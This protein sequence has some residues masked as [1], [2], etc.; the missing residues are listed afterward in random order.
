MREKWHTIDTARGD[1]VLYAFA[2]MT[3]PRVDHREPL[4]NPYVAFLAFN[5]SS[6]LYI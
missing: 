6:S 4:V 5:L 3:A 2:A 1:F